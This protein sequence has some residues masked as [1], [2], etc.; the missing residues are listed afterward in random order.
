M[1]SVELMSDYQDHANRHVAEI[2]AALRNEG[3]ILLRDEGYDLQRFSAL[4]TQLCVRL[5][6]DP[7]RDFSSK[8]T[9]TV[10]AGSDAVGLHIE[11]GNTPLPPDIVAF[12]SAL[13]ARFGAQTTLCD[14]AAVYQA[15]PEVLRKKFLQPV[16][17]TRFLP[18]THWQR[19][20]AKALGSESTENISL[21]KLKQF[22]AAIPGQSFVEAADG[23]IDY[24]LTFNPIRKDNCAALPSFAN[25]ILGPSYN[26]QTPHYQFADGQVID[27]TLMAQLRD[28]CE[29]LTTEI[30]WQDGDVVVMDNKRM[31]HGRRR[32][33]VPLSERKLYIGMGL[34][35]VG[36][37]S[38]FKSIH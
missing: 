3:W 23:G 38:G 31:M 19:Y 26:Y 28:I 8:E 16:T 2:V 1:S 33:P 29:P 7:A 17:V 14:G 35:L 13:S 22:I 4:M 25:A 9:Q 20:V 5:T 36:C 10:D 32:I 12:H 15:L 30:A 37:E 11:N 24:S 18:Q 34:G 27:A 6:F 21:A